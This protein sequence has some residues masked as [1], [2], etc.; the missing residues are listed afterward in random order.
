MNTLLFCIPLKANSLEKFED[1]IKQTSND[2]SAEWKDMLTRYDMSCVKVWVKHIEARDYVFVYHEVGPDFA[3][4]IQG[5]D[6][7]E[8]PFDQ[9]FNAAIMSVYDTGPVDAAATSLLE[10]FV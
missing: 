6:T 5:W 1:F 4:K 8:H 2:K 3:A 10:L 9:W 7:S